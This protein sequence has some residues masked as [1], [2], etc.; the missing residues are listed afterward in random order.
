MLSLAGSHAEF[1]LHSQTHVAIFWPEHLI[2]FEQFG[3]ESLVSS[4]CNKLHLQL[5]Q[6]SAN[7]KSWLAWLN[8]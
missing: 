6:N 4:N 1:I 2:C 8:F 3:G 7:Q 5:Q